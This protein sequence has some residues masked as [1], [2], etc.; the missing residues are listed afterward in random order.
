MLL[1]SAASSAML[2]VSVASPV[3]RA[4]LPELLLVS[5]ASSPPLPF[6]PE[7]ASATLPA[8]MASSAISVLTFVFLETGM[9]LVSAASSAMLPVSVASPVVRASL[10]FY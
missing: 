2:P 1:V 7:I 4:S 3:V 9:L 8:S 10:N 6:A 5:A